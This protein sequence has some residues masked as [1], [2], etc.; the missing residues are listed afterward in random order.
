MCDLLV[1][2][3]GTVDPGGVVYG[4]NHIPQETEADPSL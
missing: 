4:F 3:E 1:A 2:K